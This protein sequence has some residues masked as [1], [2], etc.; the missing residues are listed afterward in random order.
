M[1]ARR[2]R[3]AVGFAMLAIVLLAGTVTAQE[4]Q[5]RMDYNQARKE[6]AAKGKP[7]ILDFG[8]AEC[9]WC[10]RLNATTLR[11]PA[12]VKLVNE[13]F[14]PLRIDAHRDSALAD[15]LHIKS[16]PTIV[17]A[18]PEGRILGTLEG[19]M[20]SLR[21]GENLRRVL[22][23]LMNPEWMSR[24]YQEAAKAIGSSDYARAVALLKS[25]VEDGKDRPV[26]V[27]SRQLLRDLEQQAADRL[28]RAKQLEE[29]GKTTEAVETVSQ[30]M[31][32]YAGTQAASE[33]ANL[34]TSLTSKP[35]V[36]SNIRQARARE[37]LAQAREDYRSQQ[38][39]CCLD[40]C[41]LLASVYADLRES[42]DG[43][44]LAA[45]IKNN[46]EWLQAACQNLSDRLATLYVAQAETW[47][48][49][50]Q[51]Q[52]AIVCLKR[53]VQAF[54]GTRQA[55]TAKIRLATLQGKPTLQADFKK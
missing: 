3:A 19:Y 23:G 14:I 53:V 38:F 12:I 26:Q 7:L 11:D 33:C 45:E 18:G 8:T 13:Q 24:D 31:R 6:A 28:A 15:V 47:L 9:F 5:W 36:R 37:I 25:I 42:A 44:Q 2:D 55:E 51:P 40:R 29:D 4:I 50:G 43:L 41:E 48:K 46:P 30:L 27:K 10:K 1:C 49:K 17:L 21:M 34:L 52:Q 20:D 54:P 39:L 16:F 32:T 35:E 22:A